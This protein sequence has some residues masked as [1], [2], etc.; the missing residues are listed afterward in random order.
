MFRALEEIIK[1]VPS[2][3]GDGVKLT[4]F[5]G[6]ADLDVLDPL[7]LLDRFENDKSD[8]GGAGFPPHPHRGF[9]TVT[10]M[11]EGKMYHKDNK[12]N[13][14]TIHPGEMQWMRAASGIIHS[15]T[16]LPVDG[17]FK[18]FQLWLNLPALN[19][20]DPSSYQQFQGE[21]IPVEKTETGIEIRVIAGTTES[22]LE[23]ALKND[24]TEPLFLDITMT[25][26]KS[27]EQSIP[28]S[29]T[30]II[31]MIN[32]QAEISGSKIGKDELGVLGAGAKVSII[33]ENNSRFLLIAGKRLNEPIIR[34]GP[35]VMNTKEEIQQAFSDYKSGKFKKFKLIK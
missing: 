22:G 9:E 16:P 11:L 28:D 25:K 35:F 27:F 34:G 33:S 30:A 15:E 19:K 32:G 8:G 14:G 7:L 23:G 5:I 3:D 31:M 6:T 26:G 4:R 10:Y 1:G 13:E 12:G 29:H 18:G 21:D 20:S 2:A 17:K 24:L